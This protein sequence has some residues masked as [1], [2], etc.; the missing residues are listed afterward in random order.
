MLWRWMQQAERKAVC[1]YWPTSSLE[2]SNF[3]F[4]DEHFCLG[5]PTTLNAHIDS[6]T[7][8]T[9]MWRNSLHSLNPSCQLL[10]VD[11]CTSHVL[12]GSLSRT[13]YQS[14]LMECRYVHDPY[15]ACLL[16]V[17]KPAAVHLCF[18]WR[19]K[20]FPSDW[21]LCCFDI[22]P[23][24]FNMSSGLQQGCSLSPLLYDIHGQNIK[25]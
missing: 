1:I 6:H 19:I 23:S 10:I 14:T 5:I 20:V 4:S 7:L 11:V 3:Q 17:C 18:W 12:M 2:T 21:E 9:V 13:C 24:M 15:A 16:P 25:A 22:K 8:R